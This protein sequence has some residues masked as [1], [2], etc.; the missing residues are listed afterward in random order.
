MLSNKYYTCVLC[1]LLGDYFISVGIVFIVFVYS[2]HVCYYC[3]I[4]LSYFI[5]VIYVI[6]SNKFVNY[7]QSLI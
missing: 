7:S 2:L 3:V 6:I 4:N 5:N 1:I